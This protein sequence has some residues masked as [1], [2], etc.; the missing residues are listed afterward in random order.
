[1]PSEIHNG[2][3]VSNLSSAPRIRILDAAKQLFA[4]YGFQRTGM[5][6]IAKAASVSRPALYLHFH[7]KEEVYYALAQFMVDEALDAATKAWDERAGFEANLLATI[8]AKDL[9][10]YRLLIASPHGAALLAI[11]SQTTTKFSKTLHDAFVALL[12]RRAKSCAAKG[13]IDLAPFGSAK[14]FGELFALTAAG[15]KYEAG[16]EPVYI[17][18]ITRYCRVIAAALGQP[19]AKVGPRRKAKGSKVVDG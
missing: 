18:L 10:F 17:D 15:V 6:D 19:M 9:S 11:D 7:S 5:V 14:D 12:T 13:E 8:L 4:Q 1:M 16:S 3:Q 2:R